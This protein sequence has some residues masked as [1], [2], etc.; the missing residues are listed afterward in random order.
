MTTRNTRLAPITGD[1]AAAISNAIVSLHRQRAGKG[2]TK[3]KT[4]VLDDVLL[5]VL[6]NGSAPIERTLA[7]HGRA[8]LVHE[9]RRSFQDA[10]GDAFIAVVE[11]ETGRK[12]RAFLSQSHP[13]PDVSVEVFLLEPVEAGDKHDPPD[14]DATRDGDGSR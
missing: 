1:R 8:D 3:A 11:R 2:P 10:M 5:V 14:A 4:H 7:E 6:E 9:V 13:D 12:V